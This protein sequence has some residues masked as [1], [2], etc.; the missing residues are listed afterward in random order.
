[1]NSFPHL[2]MK[3]YALLLFCPLAAVSAVA[4][5]PGSPSQTAAGVAT[6]DNKAKALRRQQALTAIRQ[7]NLPAA[8]DLL[9]Q[10]LDPKLGAPPAEVQLGGELALM[11]FRLQ[12]NKEVRLARD[13][14]ASAQS[15]LDRGRAQSNPKDAAATRMIAAQLSEAVAQD[16]AQ[17]IAMYEAALAL[18]PTL[19]RASERIQHL[20]AIDEAAREKVTANEFLRQRAAQAKR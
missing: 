3:F 17:A 13:V 8:T 20:R 11:A 14:A 7:G 4:Q 5:V 19:R 1:M 16:R 6:S 12:E 18:D 2:P 15:V 10:N 9:R